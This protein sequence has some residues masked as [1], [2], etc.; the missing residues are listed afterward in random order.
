MPPGTAMYA[1]YAAKKP[2]T[3]GLIEALGE[4][5]PLSTTR[6]EQIQAL[7]TWARQRAV[8]ASSP[9][10]REQPRLSPIRFS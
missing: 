6:V 7:R 1:A 5:V 2:L 4:T 3:E 9:E 8:P 10:A